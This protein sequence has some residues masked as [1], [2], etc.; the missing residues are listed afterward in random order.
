MS[1]KPTL[2]QL[3]WPESEYQK[4]REFTDIC[5]DEIACMGYAK[6]D[7]NKVIIDE[8]FL[9][10]QVISLGNVEFIETGLPYAV[11]RA[12][13]EGRLEEL[14]FCWHSH[15]T[16]GA[17]FS[18]TDED[19]VR[20]IRDTSLID[21]FASA[22]LNKKGDTHAQIDFF[23]HR[24]QSSTVGKF[25][26][27]VTV[28]LDFTVEGVKLDAMEQR[29][30]EIEK[31]CIKKTDYKKSQDKAD[32]NTKEQRAKDDAEAGD[33][34]LLPTKMSSTWRK[35]TGRDWK[36]HNDAKKKGWWAYVPDDV[37]IAYYWDDTNAFMGSAPIPLEKNGDWKI[38]VN[39]NVIDGK[40]ED[41]EDPELVPLN[42][43]DDEHLLGIAENAG[44]L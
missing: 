2:G 41:A 40:A 35:P 21:W 23:P 34:V 22:V 17:F 19:M 30:E 32:K 12:K 4:V 18:S 37:D 5:P 6:L 9:V 44:Q 3:V 31:L 25:A 26:K 29:I 43:D 13:A 16:H 36:L 33:L 38:D 42:T 10:P 1:S 24:D 7:G 11:E 15:A 8:V 27:Q 20:K 14:R 28:N 39:V